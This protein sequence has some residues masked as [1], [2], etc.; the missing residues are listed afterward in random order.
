MKE[1]VLAIVAW[2]IAV[3]FTAPTLAADVTAAKTKAD[4]IRLAACGTRRQ[5]LQSDDVR[6]CHPSN[7]S[8]GTRAG[9]SS[10]RRCSGRAK[11]KSG[12]KKSR[13]AEDVQTCEC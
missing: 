1:L 5:G 6:N 9:A 4:A 11:Q 2:G 7:R 10:L 13:A 3:A 12:P 8:P